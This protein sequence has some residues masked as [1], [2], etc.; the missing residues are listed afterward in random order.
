ML[1]LFRKQDSAGQRS[2]PGQAAKQGHDDRTATTQA[3]R[4]CW[5]EPVCRRAFL[6]LTEFSKR[7][8]KSKSAR[9][10]RKCGVQ[11]FTKQLSW[12]DIACT[13]PF[14]SVFYTSS[15]HA[16]FG[17]F[18]STMELLAFASRQFAP[19]TMDLSVR[20]IHSHSVQF[21]LVSERSRRR[22]SPAERSALYYTLSY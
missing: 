18:S 11:S 10:T 12:C 2:Q 9:P 8:K 17:L 20:F 16:A 14:L 13:L 22:K 19:K 15:M 3:S 21:F 5:L 4:H 1:S 7:R 6:Q